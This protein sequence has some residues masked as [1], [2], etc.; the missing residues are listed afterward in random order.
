MYIIVFCGFI[1]LIQREDEMMSK[2]DEN[3][4]AGLQIACQEII[5]TAERLVRA[6]AVAD[7]RAWNSKVLRDR[8]QVQAH[9]ALSHIREVLEGIDRDIE[10]LHKPPKI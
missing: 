1:Q 2:S 9:L 3:R 4:V 5:A 7:D 8:T 6:F 10:R